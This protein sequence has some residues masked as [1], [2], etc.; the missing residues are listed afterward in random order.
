MNGWIVD[1]LGPV[2]LVG[3]GA[4]SVADVAEAMSLAPLCVAADGGAR[5]ALAAGV[6]VHAVIGDFDSIGP[7]LDQIA[8]ER[9]IRISEQDSTDFDKALRHVAAPVVVAVGFTGGRLD[10]Q[11]AALHVL[12]AYPDR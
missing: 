12:A 10:H 3:G 5:L 4:G 1:S 8:P 11:L 6:E 2:T 9:R 7:E